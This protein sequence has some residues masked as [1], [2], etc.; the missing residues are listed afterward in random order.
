[1]PRTVRTGIQ[2]IYKQGNSHHAKERLTKDHAMQEQNTSNTPKSKQMDG[3]HLRLSDHD[4]T[5][6]QKLREPQNK[7][8]PTQPREPKRNKKAPIAGATKTS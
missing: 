6:R 2:K 7:Q 1:M 3:K 8:M 5:D 4:P